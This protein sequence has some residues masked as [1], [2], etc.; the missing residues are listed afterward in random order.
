MVTPLKT[1]QKLFKCREKAPGC[2]SPYEKWTSNIQMQACCRNP[3]C[4]LSR[5]VK[6]REKREAGEAKKQRAMTKQKKDAMLPI[7]ARLKKAREETF[8]PYIRARDLA[9]FESQDK[10]PACIM[11]GKTN[12]RMWHAAHFQSV[13]SRP[14]LQFHPA[15]CHLSC[16]QCNL[17]AAQS[18]TRYR[19]NLIVKVGMVVVDYLENY[20]STIR[21]QVDEIKEIRNHFKELC[22]EIS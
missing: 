11:C 2:Q 5:S 12:P 15:N 3:N 4:V 18:D 1:K 21:W 6:L 8:Q 13:G 22:K 17:F 7:A 16:D 14:E 9:W 20:T 10:E 19:E